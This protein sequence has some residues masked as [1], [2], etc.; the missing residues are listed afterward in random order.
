M[1]FHIRIDSQSIAEQLGVEKD[2]IMAALKE[3]VKTLAIRT[4]AFI[5]EKARSELEGYMLEAYLGRSGKSGNLGTNIRL[6]HVSD[7]LHVIELDQKAMWIEDGRKPTFMGDWMLQSAKT[8]TAKDGSRYLVVP[9]NLAH[10]AGKRQGGSGAG[11]PAL[12]TMARSA[13]QK[14]RPRIAAGKIA[15]GADGKPQL[16][17]LTKVPIDEPDRTVS[18]FFSRPRSAEMAALTGLK[19]H[20]GIFYGKGAHLTQKKT[21]LLNGKESTSRDI[22]TFRV[23]SSKHKAE[24]RWMYPEVKPFGAFDAAHKWAESQLSDMVGSLGR[25]IGIGT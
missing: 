10:L 7:V 17:S 25:S 4:H 5:I 22:T 6:V 8:K 1:Q 3:D 19:A 18:G 14:V 16:G 15:Y 12:E 9:F 23:L 20:E 24:G 21:R 13:L 2:N 11:I